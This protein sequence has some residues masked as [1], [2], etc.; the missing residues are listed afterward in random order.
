MPGVW[1][2]EIERGV[3]IRTCAAEPPEARTQAKRSLLHG[4]P[5]AIA[6]GLHRDERELAHEIT[7]RSAAPAAD[8]VSST[9]KRRLHSQP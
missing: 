6:S 5:S 7:A 2:P 4:W 1:P 3:I 8:V 9:M